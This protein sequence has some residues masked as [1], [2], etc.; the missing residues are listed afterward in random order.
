MSS[1]TLEREAG[2][3]AGRDRLRGSPPG[4]DHTPGYGLA[5]QPPSS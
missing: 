3:D 2:F 4:R 5:G 1:E